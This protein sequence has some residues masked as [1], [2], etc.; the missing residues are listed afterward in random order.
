[1]SADSKDQQSKSSA[2]T[3]TAP[4]PVIVAVSATS[5]PG[6]GKKD[7]SNSSAN[8]GTS[9][10]VHPAEEA[11]SQ[12]PL[13]GGSIDPSVSADEIE[14]QFKGEIQGYESMQE[15]R[16]HSSHHGLFANARAVGPSRH[17]LPESRVMHKEKAI[18]FVDT[19]N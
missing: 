11:K 16:S 4:V 1:M 12:K 9:S 5:Q 18:S 14:V 8:A 19:Y 2:S 7:A 10:A 17:E 15:L 6:Q 3:K 13:E